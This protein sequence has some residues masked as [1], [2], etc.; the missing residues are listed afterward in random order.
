MR[1]LYS[2]VNAAQTQH[3][4]KRK[5]KGNEREERRRSAGQTCLGDLARDPSDGVGQ[6]LGAQVAAEHLTR[7]H[8]Q[9]REPVL[10]SLAHVLGPLIELRQQR[11]E[12]LR[13]LRARRALQCCTGQQ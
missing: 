12:P 2:T 4:T 8:E 6:L 3:N 10:E 7:A 5:D 11:L 9:R 13:V 1:D